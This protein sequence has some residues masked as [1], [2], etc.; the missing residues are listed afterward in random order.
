MRHGVVAYLQDV[1][2]LKTEEM[3]LQNALVHNLLR[4]HAQ[5]EELADQFETSDTDDA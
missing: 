3:Q 5:L 2:K 4:Q 1:K